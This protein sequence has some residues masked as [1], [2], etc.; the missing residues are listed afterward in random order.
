L[1]QNRPKADS[2]TAAKLF[3]HFIG[4]NIPDTIAR[5]D[6]I[7]AHLSARIDAMAITE[8]QKASRALQIASFCDS[9]NHIAR[10]LDAI[11]Q[12]RATRLRREAKARE[13]AEARRV[14]EMLDALPSPDDPASYEH[15]NTGDLSTPLPPTNSDNEGDL[16]ENLLQTTPPTPGN[17]SSSDP[18]E[19]GY[20]EQSKYRQMPAMSLASED[21]Y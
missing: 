1:Q 4:S 9:V 8:A 21:D 18:S 13:D 20:P 11:E 7:H 3:D 15:F 14:Q 12:R 16:R 19:L 5:N 10:R 17:Y 2:C 6:S